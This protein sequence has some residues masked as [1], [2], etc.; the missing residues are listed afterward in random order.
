MSNMKTR[1]ESRLLSLLAG[2]E[3]RSH[4]PK[5]READ[6]LAVGDVGGSSQDADA[7]EEGLRSWTEAD[8][9]WQVVTSHRGQRNRSA[10]S[11]G[12]G[13]V[14]GGS[15]M[16]YEREFSTR[17][18]EPSLLPKGPRGSMAWRPLLL[19]SCWR[20]PTGADG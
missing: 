10:V 12:R 7:D 2:S 14:K 16:F 13:C 20:D 17:R 6:C 1:E 15:E 3:T 18:G 9:G 4:A 11:G 19:M 8:A 5:P